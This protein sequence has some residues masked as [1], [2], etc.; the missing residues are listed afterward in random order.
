MVIRTT[1]AAL[2]LSLASLA[3]ATIAL[4]GADGKTLALKAPAQ[5][6]V[7]LAPDLTELV[8]AAGA[9]DTMVGTSAYSDYPVAAKKL[10]HIG[11]A[12]RVDIERLLA[13]RPDL[14]LAWQGGTPVA[15]IEHLRM[16]KLP[17]LV[18]GTRQ[19][20]DIAANLE[21]IGIAT[22]HLQTAQAAAR[23]FRTDL[24][25]LRS[26]YAERPPVRVFYEISATPLYTIGGRQLIS[27][28]IELCGGR[29][30][31]S[32]LRPLAAEVSL[33]SVL[34]RNPQ[35]VVTGDSPEAAADL[36]QWQH[37]PQL[38]AVQNQSLFSISGDL[39]DRATP[40]VLAGGQQLCKDLET[41]RRRL[42]KQR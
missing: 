4:T 15:V 6:V 14:V 2:L 17:V 3:H 30:V 40:R 41:T 24:E 13:L 33:E 19:L 16:L 34:A 1:V 9:G 37:W 29:N 42:D 21:L 22:G 38:S 36:Q 23:N 39:L 26:K 28:M 5:R 31:F 32:D 18:I 11:D 20:A 8:Y 35:A 10:P 7:S 25:I 12:F 27:R